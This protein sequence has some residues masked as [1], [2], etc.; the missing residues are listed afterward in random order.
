V[1]ISAGAEH[2][3]DL[4]PGSYFGEIALLRN[5]P[6][7]ATVTARTDVGLWT[8]DRDSFVLAVAGEAESS[9]VA[10]AVIERRLANT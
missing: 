8:L 6:R 5:V 3:G 4:G 7:T 1:E 9:A 10:N 2:V